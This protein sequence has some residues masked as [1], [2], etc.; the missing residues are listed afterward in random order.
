MIQGSGKPANQGNRF[1]RF[2]LP[3][4]VILLAC[5]PALS[6]WSAGARQAAQAPAP[7]ITRAAADAC[8]IKVRKL[9]ANAAASVPPEKV[10]TRATRLSETELNSYFEIIL[11]PQY[12]PS[13]RSIRFTLGESQLSAT[14]AIDFD[15]LQIKSAQFWAGLVSKMFTGVHYLAIRGA[16]LSGDGKGS[17]RLDEAQ[18]D[19]M[20]LPNLLVAEIISAVGRRQNPPFDPIQPSVLPYGIRKVELRK[21]EMIVY[22]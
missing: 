9:Q 6:T 21:A 20:T 18:F 7:G 10:G 2:R 14:A 17:F 13:L 15:H 16:V 3:I 22:Q 5:A 19:G 11:R 1:D 4:C 8:D 12:H